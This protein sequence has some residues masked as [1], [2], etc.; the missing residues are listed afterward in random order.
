MFRIKPENPFFGSSANSAFGN[1]AG[2]KATGRHVKGP[3]PGRRE[4]RTQ[5]HML[6]RTGLSRYSEGGGSKLIAL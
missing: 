5:Q 3:V 6:C 4:F 1:K 2:N